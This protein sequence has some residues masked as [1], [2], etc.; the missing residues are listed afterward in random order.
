MASDEKFKGKLVFNIGDK[1]DFSYVLEDY[2]ISL[3]EKKDVGVGMW[4]GRTTTG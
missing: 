4:T 2:D 3:P 1:E